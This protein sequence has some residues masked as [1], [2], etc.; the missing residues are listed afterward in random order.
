MAQRK[1]FIDR[2]TG[3][4]HWTTPR[5]FLERVERIGPIGIDPCGNRASGQIADLVCL[6]PGEGALM[7]GRHLVNVSFED[8]LLA[9]WGAFAPPSSGRLAFANPPYGR[10]IVEWVEKMCR[11]G[12]R[13]VEIV[14]LLPSR[15][16]V[17]WMQ[18]RVWRS[19]VAGRFWDGRI[20]FGNPPPPKCKVKGCPS[21][22]KDLA[23]NVHSHEVLFGHAF[24][25]KDDSGSTIDNFVA[26]WGD[27]PDAFFAAF[28]GCGRAMRCR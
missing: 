26:Y 14:A 20:Q 17:K 21:V 5:S 18:R 16:G 11:E 12:E 8:G 24:V 6:G 27:R 23:P 1:T 28:R 22:A 15:T 10:A 19:A 3:W 4:P 2:E 25:P 7:E 9:D 13:G